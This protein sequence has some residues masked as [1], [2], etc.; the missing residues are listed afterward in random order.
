MQ[1]P[2]YHYLSSCN[3][4]GVTLGWSWCR[5]GRAVKQGTHPLHLLILESAL[6]LALKWSEIINFLID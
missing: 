6:L 3:H 2:D 4:E 5:D 1:S